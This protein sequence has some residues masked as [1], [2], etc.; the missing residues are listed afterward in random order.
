MNNRDRSPSRGSVVS[1]GSGNLCVIAP[2]DAS[3][4]GHEAA[5]LGVKDVG[6]GGKMPKLLFDPGSVEMMEGGLL[7]APGC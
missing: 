6:G 4:A 3:P 5:D 2:I 7:L 1:D